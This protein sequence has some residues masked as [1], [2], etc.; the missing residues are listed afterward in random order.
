MADQPAT[1]KNIQDLGKSIN[2]QLS[3]ISKILKGGKA[4]ETKD[5]KTFLTAIESIFKKTAADT[6]TVGK[7]INTQFSNISKI[8]KESNTKL[9]SLSKI[10]KESKSPEIADTGLSKVLT[11]LSKVLKGS[12]EDKKETKDTGV[13]KLLKGNK[14]QEVEDKREQGRFNKR[15]LEAITSMKASMMKNFKGFKKADTKTGGILSGIFSGA[16]AAI[17]GMVKGVGKLG[18]GFVTGMLSLGGGIAAFL[19]AL[20]GAD[21]LL[22]LMGQS[23]DN[24]KTLV[25][26]FFGAFDAKA[27][28]MMAGVIGAATFI[29]TLSKHA[30][31]KLAAGMTAIG[32]GIAGF[33]SGI[34]LGEKGLELI[35]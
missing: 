11:D 15:F 28:I 32:A 20:G 27:G 8:L 33:F 9:S 6:K 29:T 22:G 7:S 2:T 16:G 4:Q 18:T 23:G 12:T 21:K 17:M 25:Q 24:L 31:L 34:L 14:A 26:N 13:V 3:G 10:L 35:K 30:P 5:R 1:S 19:I